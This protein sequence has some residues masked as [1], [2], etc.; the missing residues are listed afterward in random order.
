M[1][2]FAASNIVARIRSFYS[3][4]K[5]L[6]SKHSESSTSYER[7][8]G[9]LFRHLPGAGVLRMLRSC[10]S[11]HLATLSLLKIGCDPLFAA[12]PIMQSIGNR[13]CQSA[14]N[15]HHATHVNVKFNKCLQRGP[16]SCTCHSP[17]F[18]LVD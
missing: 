5:L 12:R 9:Y 1:S 18:S 13:S 8:T 3:L 6:D 14:G 4:M 7:N 2:S 15:N 17:I 10:S 11:S 16:L